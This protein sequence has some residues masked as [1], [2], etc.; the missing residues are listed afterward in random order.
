MKAPDT[1]QTTR[2]LVA[3]SNA[4]DM[5]RVLSRGRALKIFIF[6]YIKP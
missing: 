1:D 3:A 5:V 6:L 2:N 4:M